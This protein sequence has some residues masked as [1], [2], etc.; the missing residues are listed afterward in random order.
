MFVTKLLSKYKIFSNI[1]RSKQET[2]VFAILLFAM[3]TAIFA[4]A[5]PW[6]LFIIAII[7]VIIPTLLDFVNSIISRK[8]GNIRTKRFV[9]TIDGL[10]ASV[11]R[12]ILDV[13]LIPD[14]MYIT[15]KAECKT[16]YRMTKSKKH[17]LEW[18]TSEEAEKTAKTD[19][20][21]YYKNMG[22]NTIAG[23]VGILVVLLNQFFKIKSNGVLITIL[24][25]P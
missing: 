1:V 17:L 18:M 9:K 23:I 19:I 11:L 8:Q 25:F 4:K 6:N 16:I 15:L 10:K 3:L 22:A 24:I 21:S 5:I 12:A 20:I 13:L 7:S 2:K 14:K